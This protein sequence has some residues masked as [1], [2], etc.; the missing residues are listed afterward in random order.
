MKKKILY[1]CW[2]VSLIL[3]SFQKDLKADEGIVGLYHFDEGRGWIV[4]DSSG[5]ENNGEIKGEVEWTT[6]KIGRALNFNGVDT[7]VEIPYSDSLNLREA[8]TVEAWIKIKS[9]MPGIVEKPSRWILQT[10]GTKEKANRLVGKICLEKE[11][12]VKWIQIVGLPQLQPDT[13]YHVAMTYD[14]KTREF[15]IYVNGKWNAR[16]IVEGYKE[17]KLRESWN[18]IYIGY[19]AHWNEY[20]EGTI[21]EVKIYNRALS[22]KEIKMHY[23]NADSEK[24]QTN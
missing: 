7:K 14:S 18:S 13:W 24:K 4:K 10:W 1:F 16:M 9:H 6:G 23:K 5:H 22:G 19:T 2:I 3:F 8:L 12:K 15:I 17:Y 11:G 20:S 21:D